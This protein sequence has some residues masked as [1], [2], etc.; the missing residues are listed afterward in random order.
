L[1]K[2]YY[3]KGRYLYLVLFSLDGPSRKQ[4]LRRKIDVSESA[5]KTW[6]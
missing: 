2:K 5:L 4:V 3:G 1:E 6:Y